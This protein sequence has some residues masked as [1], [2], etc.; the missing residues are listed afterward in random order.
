MEIT[1]SWKSEYPG[2]SIGVLVMHG[3]ENPQHHPQLDEKKKDLEDT[4]RAQFSSYDRRSLR[5]IPVLASYRD[6]YK[7]FNGTYHVQHQLESVVFKNRH[8]PRVA[9]LVE[10][11][12][13]AEL[14]NLLLTAGHDLN[15]IMSPLRIDVAKGIE[16]YIRMNGEEQILKAGDMMIADANGIVSCIIYG[17]DRRTRIR[18]ETNRVVFTVYAP[19]GIEERDVS[20]H[21]EDIRENVT[22]IAPGASVE[23]L[24][25]FGTY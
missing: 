11:M 6:Y 16:S 9:A 8:I 14:K 5:A 25:T 20:R 7:Q 3:V 12:F 15:T 21:L 22:V 18:P 10:A 23:L 19:K 13:M 4:L 1:S 17:P 24:E 2:S